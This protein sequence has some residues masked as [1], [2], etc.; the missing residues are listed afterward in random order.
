MHKRVHIIRDNKKL[1]SNQTLE[2]VTSLSHNQGVLGSSP[3]GTTQS[4]S[5]S[6]KNPENQRFSG[7]FLFLQYRRILQNEA[8]RVGLF[9]GLDFCPKMSNDCLITI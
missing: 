7:F 1:I 4:E 5:K 3:S 9:V 2:V 6:R 8:F